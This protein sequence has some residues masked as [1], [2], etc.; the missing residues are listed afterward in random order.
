MTGN[1][2]APASK[3]RAPQMCPTA[4]RR[5]KRTTAACTVG[6]DFR[7][8][9]PKVAVPSSHTLSHTLGGIALTEHRL[10]H[11]TPALRLVVLVI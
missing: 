4:P 5:R 10:R 2:A 1:E 8:Q 3:L 7:E 6:L 9:H 11:N